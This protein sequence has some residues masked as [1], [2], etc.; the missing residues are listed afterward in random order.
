MTRKG[1]MLGVLGL[2]G[3]KGLITSC[4]KESPPIS[5]ASAWTID[6]KGTFTSMTTTKFV[7][8]FGSITIKKHPLL[9]M[10]DLNC[11]PLSPKKQ[12]ALRYWHENKLS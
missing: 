8:P 12:K 2:L 11:E 3:F 6:N 10:D 1:F 9:I 7:S 4:K 5:L